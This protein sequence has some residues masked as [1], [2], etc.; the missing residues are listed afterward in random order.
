MLS[1]TFEVCAPIASTGS[2]KDVASKA[3]VIN[4][5][6]EAARTKGVGI[7]PAGISLHAFR[8]IGRAQGRFR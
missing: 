6:E 7:P 5:T 2:T 3:V 4:S 8:K 1:G